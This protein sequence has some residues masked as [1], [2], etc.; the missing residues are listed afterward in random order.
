MPDRLARDEAGMPPAVDASRTRRASTACAGPW[1]SRRAPA[2]RGRGP[3]SASHLPHPAA[4]DPLL[5]ARARRLC[6][7]QITPPLAPPKRDVDDGALPRHP[8]RE[9]AHRVEGLLGVE[10]DAALARSAGV[11]V[12]DAEAAEDLQRRRRPCAPGWRRNTRGVGRAGGRGRLRR[13]RRGPPLDRTGSGPRRR[14]C[15]ASMTWVHSLVDRVQGECRRPPR[16][17]SGWAAPFQRA[18]G[19]SPQADQGLGGNRVIPRGC[20]RRMPH[21]GRGRM[22]A[23]CADGV[24]RRGKRTCMPA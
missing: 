15:R 13:G 2:R 18:R 9:G 14:S 4:A 17:Q 11:V 23:V 7:S 21:R 1:S 24:G 19:R 20:R 12:L 22:G 6:G 5:L 8:H 3:T 10:A 16:G